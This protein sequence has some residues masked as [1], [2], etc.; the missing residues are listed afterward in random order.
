MSDGSSTVP[1]DPETTPDALIERF[2]RDL[3]NDFDLDAPVF[4]DRF[5]ETLN[6]MV[7]KCPVV[8]STVGRG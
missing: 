5:D 8:H 4:N 3:I 1:I 7:R 6:F 2:G